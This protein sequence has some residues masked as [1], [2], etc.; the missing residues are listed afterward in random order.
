MGRGSNEPIKAIWPVRFVV[1]RRLCLVRCRHWS[2]GFVV[3][4]QPGLIA[5]TRETSEDDL[6]CLLDDRIVGEVFNLPIV[7]RNSKL[8]LNAFGIELGVRFVLP[9][10]TANQ[11]VCLNGI[12]L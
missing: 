11:C 12:G 4:V 8:L 6:V 1:L 7:I 9:T 3:R 5:Q 10:S 2:H